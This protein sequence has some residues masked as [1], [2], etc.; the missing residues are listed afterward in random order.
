[1]SETTHTPTPWRRAPSWLERGWV[2]KSGDIIIAVLNRRDK[3]EWNEA[4]ATF[5]VRACNS[6]AKLLAACRDLL[7]EPL[8]VSDKGKLG[9]QFYAYRTTLERRKKAEATIREAEKEGE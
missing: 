4:N 7:S 6:H 1:M 3:P 2:I 8:E 9:G 5:I